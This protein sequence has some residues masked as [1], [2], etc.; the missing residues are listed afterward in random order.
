MSMTLRIGSQVRMKKKTVMSRRKVPITR[1]ASHVDMS[2]V[3]NGGQEGVKATAP[4]R[5][6]RL[7]GA[8]RR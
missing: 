1:T 5:S 4:R 6:R 3:A 8:D 2:L 7:S